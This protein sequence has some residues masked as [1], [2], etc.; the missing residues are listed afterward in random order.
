MQ[1]AVPESGANVPQAPL[2]GASGAVRHSLLKLGW[3]KG[4]AGA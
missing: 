2:E 3:G 1:V 4:E